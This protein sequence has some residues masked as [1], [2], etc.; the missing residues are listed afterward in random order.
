MG[1][2]RGVGGSGVFFL[3]CFCYFYYFS[4]LFIFTC[5]R[6]IHV[7]DRVVTYLPCVLKLTVLNFLYKGR[8]KL[9]K[10]FTSKV[11]LHLKIC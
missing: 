4:I 9:H 8:V 1:W 2:G 3:I 5:L 11:E 7:S 10:I 6:G